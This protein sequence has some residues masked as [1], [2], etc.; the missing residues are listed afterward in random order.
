MN[1]FNNNSCSLLVF[2]KA[3]LICMATLLM[4]S[5]D[6]AAQTPTEINIE[7]DYMVER[8]FEG[9]IIFSH[10]PQQDEID[11]V[12]Q[13]FA[14]QGID[15]FIFVDDEI[16]NIQVLQRD[17]FN[18]ANF[19]GYTGSNS[20][21][22][23][24]HLYRDLGQ[25]WHYCIFAHRYQDSNYDTSSSSGLGESGGDEFIVTLAAFTDSIGT[26]FDRAA[27]LAHELGHNLE[28]NHAGNMNEDITGPNTPNYP[29]IMSYF[30]QLGG[31][32]S[33]Y[34]EMGLAPEAANLLKEIDYSWGSMC[35]INEAALDERFGIGM[36][37]LDWDCDGVIES[38][39]VVQDTDSAT[40]S[41]WCSATG[42]LS[43]LSDY[44]DWASI[45]DNTCGKSPEELDNLPIIECITYEEHQQYM[46]E[47]RDFRQ[48]PLE[49]EPCNSNRMLWAIPAIGGT[50]GGW[51]GN[52]FLGFMQAYNAA[53]AGDIIYLKYG[54][55]NVNASSILMTKRM[56][57]TAT[58]SALIKPVG[59][60]K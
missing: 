48:P 19:F 49:I 5:T 15:C 35:T 39:S 30:C 43:L 50:G 25:C 23:L 42:P 36:K 18:A 55:Y 60:G 32:R 59:K 20:F 28:L 47:H 17:P 38:G 26:P 54:T 27:T 6:A 3:F 52:P 33:R 1:R 8:D 44:N 29:S 57:I 9:N 45:R 22:I 13:M 4:M 31:V 14:C 34:M 51:C 40:L 53:W 16:P 37:K 2:A 56:I 11:A 58:S 41:N 10:E 46:A 7:I 21:G 12:I 24:K